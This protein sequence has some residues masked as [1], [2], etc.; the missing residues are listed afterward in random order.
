MPSLCFAEL[1]NGEDIFI[2]LIYRTNTNELDV[3]TC[4]LMNY[5]DWLC[6]VPCHGTV[7]AV[8]RRV[9]RSVNGTRRKSRL[10]EHKLPPSLTNWLKD[11]SIMASCLLIGPPS[12]RRSRPLNVSWTVKILEGT[13]TKCSDWKKLRTTIS[14]QGW[15]YAV[16]VVCEQLWS[17]RNTP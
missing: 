9:S 4:S 14:S 10:Q 15:K 3:V 6:L 7:P 13:P 16:V 2:W 1:V 8:G 17:R 5:L 12:R 11:L